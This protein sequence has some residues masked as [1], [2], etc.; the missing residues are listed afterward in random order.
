MS[1]GEQLVKE[2][3]FPGNYSDQV[4]D[5]LERASMVGLARLS[6][7]KIRG[8]ASIRS[9]LYAGDYDA[10][11]EVNASSMSEIVSSLKKIIKSIRN[12]C[13]I[14]DF[15]IGEVP[16]WSVVIGQIINGHLD[17][18]L[19]ESLAKLDTLK[20]EKVI[21]EAEYKGA[22]RLLRDVKDPLTFI[23]AEKG[24]RFHILRWTPAEILDGDKEYRG[25]KFTL[26]D[27]IRSRGLI[28]LDLIASIN[29]MFS[30]FSMIYNITIGKTHITPK[31][32]RA[33]IEQSL[34]DDI[35]YYNHRSPFKALKRTFSLAKMT[36]NLKEVEK[37]IP[38]LNSDLG[39]LYSIAGDLELLHTLLEFSDP[40]TAQIKDNLNEIAARMG[41]IYFLK[42]FL[43]A[44]HEILARL[45]SMRKMPLKTLKPAVFSLFNELKQILNKS[46]LQKIKSI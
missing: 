35:V 6:N 1:I 11:E 31:K 38:I 17:F 30:E 5:V 22:E 10:E 15:K 8:S 21:S 39:R 32:T 3:N 13:Y 14:T 29:E 33:E 19:P 27:A 28:K 40:P 36:N 16:E 45:N 46:T 23:E 2:K 44:E 20:S 37:L 24:I 43:A 4:L 18:K 34:K 12:D 7:I 9:Q 26:E 41:S 42:T 25:V